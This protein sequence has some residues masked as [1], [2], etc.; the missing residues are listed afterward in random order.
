MN[1]Q[2]VTEKSETLTNGG[3]KQRSRTEKTKKMICGFRVQAEDGRLSLVFHPDIEAK[4]D[5]SSSPF[6]SVDSVSPL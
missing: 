5:Y 2:E 4:P 3:T 6:V 1:C